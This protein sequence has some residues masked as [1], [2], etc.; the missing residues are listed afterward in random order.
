MDHTDLLMRSPATLALLATNILVSI[1]AFSN[2]RLLDS[3]LFDMTMIRRRHEYHR[4]ITS[5]FIHG[6]PMH[7]FMNMLALFFLG[8]YLEYSIGAWPYLGIYLASLLA[9]SLWT[10]MEH[11]R[12][13]NYR[14][15][16]ASGAVSGIT[17]AAAVFYPLSTIRVFFALPMPFILFAALYMGWSIW[18]SASRVR[19]GI[20]HA[21]H[22]GGALMGLALVCIFW[23]VVVQHSWEEIVQAVLPP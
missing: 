7:L 1:A 11:F 15:L 13:L 10:Y 16:G 20:G 21:A 5:G 9:G 17:T 12:E 22:L 4:M 19:D 3:M 14:A 18:A 23:P 6:D 2:M 8:P